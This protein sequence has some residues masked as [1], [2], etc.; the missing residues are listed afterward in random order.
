[1]QPESPLHAERAALR[2]DLAARAAAVD[3]SASFL[4]QAP[5]GSGKTTVLTCRLL[6][7]LATV[8][9]PEAVLAITFTRK[10][11]AEMR[12]RVLRALRCAAVDSNADA[13]EAPHAS[14]AW[15]HDQQR[16]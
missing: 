7:L 8:A 6:A 2:E 10:A 3:T 16:D 11:A 5:A 15:R 9:E 4:L 13:P 1:M 14:A 12:A